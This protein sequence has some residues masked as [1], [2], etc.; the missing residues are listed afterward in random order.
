VLA[1]VG[2]RSEPVYQWFLGRFIERLGGTPLY[3]T[4]LASGGFYLYAAMRGTPRALDALTAAIG[5]LAFVGPGTLDPGGLVSPRALPILAVGVAQM[6][7]G[8][9]RRQVGRCLIGTGCVMVSAMIA[10]GPAGAGGHRG[11]VAFH[12]AMASV[13]ALGAAFDDRVGRALRTI[14]AGMGLLAALAAMSGQIS[15]GAGVPSWG[16]EAYAPAMCL[17]IA[18][19][20][21]ALG[22]RASQAA[23][24]L[25]LVAWLAV[26]GG[27]GYRALR[28]LAAGLDYIAVGL[29]LFSLAVLTSLAKGGAWPRPITRPDKDEEH[30]GSALADGAL[31][32]AR[33]SGA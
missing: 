1:A 9:L 29:V 17:L 25:I 6:V 7:P 22:H 27:R 12:L 24:G 33:T 31:A 32:E 30:S 2:H 11:P 21:L 4:L 3:L 15:L 10:I 18:A 19:Y 28:Q 26:L 20:G 14:G 16:I 5:A 23:A 13:L 8:L